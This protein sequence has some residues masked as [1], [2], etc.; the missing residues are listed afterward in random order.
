MSEPQT[1]G[2]CPRN[3][4]AAAYALGAL[5]DADAFRSHL[6]TCPTCTADVAQLQQAAELLP[7]A[8]RRRAAPDTVRERI[9]AVV[10]SE[11]E[12]LRAA[13]ASSDLP[14]RRRPGIFAGRGATIAAAVAAAAAAF[15]I[16]LA[17]RSTTAEHVR[18]GTVSAALSGAQI[19]LRQTGGHAE[20]SVSNFP[21]AP[22]GKVYEVWLLRASGPPQP[23]D[24]LFGVTTHGRGAIAVPGSLRGVREVLITSEPVGGS[25]RPTSEPVARVAL[26][27]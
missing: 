4:D 13:G 8:V 15:G 19:S 12:L 20:L 23:T 21:Q 3:D 5:D 7:D 1:Q 14:R 22:F 16:A 17:V 25:L 24:A 2:S 9:L 10:R 26:A 18:R 11:A 27:A 6:A